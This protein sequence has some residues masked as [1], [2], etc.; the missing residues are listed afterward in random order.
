MRAIRQGLSVPGASKQSLKHIYT[1]HG[2]K[3]SLVAGV[4]LKSVGMDN[5]QSFF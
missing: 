2:H 4:R 5:S 3:L 1:S